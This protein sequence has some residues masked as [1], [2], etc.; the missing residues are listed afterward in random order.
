[1]N[2][3]LF[4]NYIKDK[5]RIRE[6]IIEILSTACLVFTLLFLC[7]MLNAT[8]QTHKNI[9]AA[10]AFLSFAIYLLF[11]QRPQI[12]NYQ[13]A[14]ATILYF[15]IGF[16]YRCRYIMAPDWFNRDKV[17]VWIVYI[18][19]IILVDMYIRGKYNPL[20]RMNKPFL[21]VY[22]FMT[23]SMI[24]YRNGSTMPALLLM[25][26]VVY[27]IPLNAAK[28]SRILNQIG[29]AWIISFFIILF[30]SVRLNME[31]SDLGRWYGCFVNLGDFGLFL[32]GVVVILTFRVYRALR[33]TGLRSVPFILYA[34]ACL[35]L[36]WT[37][38]RVSTITL[39]I[40]MFF[41]FIMFFILFTPNGT[42]KESLFRLFTVI[43]ILVVI[44]CL[45]LLLLKSIVLHAD[46]EYWYIQ[47]HEG[48]ALIKPIANI[49]MRAFYMFEEPITFSD[50]GIFKPD[51]IINY[52][53]L[54]TSGRLS[55]IKMFSEH[56]SFTGTVINGIDVGSYFAYNAH[57]SYVQ[58]LVE[59]G[60]IAGGAHII[61]LLYL[62][63][64]SVRRFLRSR[65]YHDLFMCLWMGMA[66]GVLTGECARLY[67]PII[68][69]TLLLSYPLIVNI[70]NKK[71]NTQ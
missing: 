33:R 16:A 29:N 24:F 19:I 14:L 23:L 1:M 6:L 34:V 47:L 71:K 63:M 60:Y 64:A 62:M 58:A 66:L 30:Q 54:F 37:I 28:W 20:E 52:L 3:D 12:I 31:V 67:T 36:L 57:N 5:R 38:L 55:I 9:Y 17:V 39:Y 51:S 18:L 13:T 69:F 59:Y 56:F 50:C 65:K 4:K 21:C 35:P 32:S 43:T 10:K 15:P 22:C 48:N 27:L 45:G 42:A 49:V 41:M 53:D 46:K 44:C 61:W 40:G 26:L 70:P 68:F 8:F 7:N 2:L 25:M 11:V